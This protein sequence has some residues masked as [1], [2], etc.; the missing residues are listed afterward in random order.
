MSHKP[1]S[2]SIKSHCTYHIHSTVGGFEGWLH[3]DIH[4]CMSIH[5]KQ[6]DTVILVI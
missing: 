1:H 5:S 3:H 6:V 2:A 4:V